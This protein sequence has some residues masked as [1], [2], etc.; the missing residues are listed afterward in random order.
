M[1]FRYGVIRVVSAGPPP[2]WWKAPTVRVSGGRG[3]NPELPA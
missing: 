1:L 2:V 3:S